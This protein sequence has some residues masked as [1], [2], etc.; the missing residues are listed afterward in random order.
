MLSRLLIV[1]SPDSESLQTLCT[2]AIGAGASVLAVS[3]REDALD[4]A[5]R[6][7]PDL[8]V[9]DVT[10]DSPDGLDLIQNLRAASPIAILAL[11]DPLDGHTV[12]RALRAGAN[13][14]LTEVP[15]D[16]AALEPRL[17]QLRLSAG[18]ARDRMI[19]IRD[20]RIDPATSGVFL[21]GERIRVTPVE[22]RLLCALAGQP[23]R[24]LSAQE[25]WRQAQQQALTSREAARLCKPHIRRVRGKIEAV[26]GTDPYEPYIVTVPG[27]GYM[28]QPAPATE[29]KLTAQL[30]GRS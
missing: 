19:Q 11:A 6:S 9:V 3:S 23:G 15:A 7:D 18:P 24:V 1:G 13:D 27:F 2:A 20:L 14:Y 30:A 26:F 22:F 29:H 25:L 12:A 5:S 8:I 28:L 16:P 21:K 4:M 17:D 10:T